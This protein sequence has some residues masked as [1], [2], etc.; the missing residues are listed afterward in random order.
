PDL[1][2][3][4][5]R[6]AAAN[7]HVYRS[8]PK[9]TASG[10]SDPLEDEVKSFKKA[11]NSL[12]IDK[13]LAM[14]GSRIVIPQA[15][16]R[17]VVKIFHDAHQGYDRS[18]QRARQAVFWPGLTSDLTNSCKLCKQCQK[19]QAKQQKE[20]ISRDPMPSRIFEEVGADFF[21][22]ENRHFL[23]VVNRLSGWPQ[24]MTKL[25]ERIN[26]QYNTTARDLPPLIVGSRVRIQN[27]SSKLWDRIR[28]IVSIDKSRDHRVK[29]GSGRILWRN[30]R[31]VQRVP[32]LKQED[33]IE[34]L[35]HKTKR[36]PH[37]EEPVHE[38]VPNQST[39]Y[40]LGDDVVAYE[41]FC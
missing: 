37:K 5:L 12:S 18:L 21:K 38:F 30:R 19:Y 23:A 15:R 36:P 3:E 34:H 33:I 25:K 10:F 9:A 13:G 8:L 6:K 41:R 32:E 14:Y 35:P 22:Y 31:F 1:I 17:E 20:T 7:D 26:F 4:D 27:Q 29:L 39:F 16:R 2:I 40:R 24:L 28:Y 11:R